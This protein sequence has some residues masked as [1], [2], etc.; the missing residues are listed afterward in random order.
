MWRMIGSEAKIHQPGFF[1]GHLLRIANVGNALIHQIFGKVI[2][3][4]RAIG[5]GG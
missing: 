3:L 1:G 5:R 4:I 2:A